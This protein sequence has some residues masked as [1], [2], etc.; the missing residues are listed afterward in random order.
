MFVPTPYTLLSVKGRGEG[1][2]GGGEW[3]VGGGGYF[4][5]STCD[6]SEVILL[7][8]YKCYVECFDYHAFLG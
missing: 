1:K 5:F 3:K 6:S 8:W 7:D 2:V 4:S